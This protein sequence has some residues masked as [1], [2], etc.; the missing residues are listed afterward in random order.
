MWALWL[1]TT[2]CHLREGGEADECAIYV[3][4]VSG[5]RHCTLVSARRS[6][7]DAFMGQVKT[8]IMTN[9]PKSRVAPGPRAPPPADACHPGPRPL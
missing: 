7:W 4:M 5:V 6:H 8:Q 9:R 3:S 1:A 2:T